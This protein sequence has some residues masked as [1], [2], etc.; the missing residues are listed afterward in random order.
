MNKVW[1]VYRKV[2][3]HRPSTGLE[4]LICL[5]ISQEEANAFLNLYPDYKYD[6]HKGEN[7]VFILEVR[8]HTIGNVYQFFEDRRKEIK[9][10]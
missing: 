5:F 3:P 6:I 2:N 9:H 1:G 4:T 10:D 7:P 8:E